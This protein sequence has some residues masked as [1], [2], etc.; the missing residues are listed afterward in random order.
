LRIK[1]KQLERET[2]PGIVV[3]NLHV[4]EWNPANGK[5]YPTNYRNV[6]PAK[7]NKEFL[8]AYR[9]AMNRILEGQTF[10]VGF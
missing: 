8:A 3:R 9:E 4:L 10:L 1:L 6:V 2:A 5:W 7:E